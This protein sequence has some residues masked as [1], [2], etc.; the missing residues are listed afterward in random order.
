MSISLKL[1]LFC[2][3]GTAGGLLANTKTNDRSQLRER[4]FCSL[5]S[6]SAGSEEQ[7]HGEEFQTAC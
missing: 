4:S 3:P 6:P 1:K 2:S 5:F 7:E